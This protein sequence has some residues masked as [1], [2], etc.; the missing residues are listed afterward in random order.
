MLRGWGVRLDGAGELV[1]GELA[2]E[3]WMVLSQFSNIQR[4][5]FGV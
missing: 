5:A 4:G 2:D 1:G 3:L